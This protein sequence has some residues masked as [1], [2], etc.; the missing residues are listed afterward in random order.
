[1]RMSLKSVR[2]VLVL[3]FELL[4]YNYL[5]RLSYFYVGGDNVACVGTLLVVFTIQA[6][7]RLAKLKTLSGGS[8]GSCI[9]EEQSKLCD[10][11]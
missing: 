3:L 1:M 6:Y 10:L 5:S 9:E 4:Q 7:G 8:L 11:L 2:P